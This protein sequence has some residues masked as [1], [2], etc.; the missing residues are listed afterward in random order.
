MGKTMAKIE[1]TAG[2]AAALKIL[3]Q[4]FLGFKRDYHSGK[5]DGD[6]MYSQMRQAAGHVLR[7]RAAVEA[8]CNGW[9]K[10]KPVTA[11]AISNYMR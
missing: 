11:A 2:E 5:G 10:P 1:Y 7:F 4:R 6:A 3:E 8:R 9:E